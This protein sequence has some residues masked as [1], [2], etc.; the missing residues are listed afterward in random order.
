MF[1]HKIFAVKFIYT[2]ILLPT[3]I[4]DRRRIATII[5]IVA[6]CMDCKYAIKI[7]KR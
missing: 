5:F 7:G 4:I 2:W 3:Q 6:I 1:K